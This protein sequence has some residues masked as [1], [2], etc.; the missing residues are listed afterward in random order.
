VPL[1][2]VVLLLVG[3]GVAQ[4]QIKTKRGKDAA[5]K[6][7]ISPTLAV[8]ADAATF[9]SS[10]SLAFDVSCEKTLSKGRL[11]L[12]VAVGAATN[13]VQTGADVGG[14]DAPVVI[15]RLH[16]TPELVSFEPTGHSTKA[17]WSAP[18]GDVQVK[19][20][21]GGED[22]KA[23][24][25]GIHVLI[26]FQPVREETGELAWHDGSGARVLEEKH[27]KETSSAFLQLFYS[28]LVNFPAALEQVADKRRETAELGF[29]DSSAATAARSNSPD[30]NAGGS[31]AGPN[32]DEVQSLLNR[33]PGTWSCPASKTEAPS[34][35]PIAPSSLPCI[36]DTY[37]WSAVL[38]AWAAECHARLSMES[39]AEQNAH[40]MM[41]S[42]NA[43]KSL[44]SSR[45]A[46]AGGNSCSTISIYSCSQ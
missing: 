13:D 25:R 18:R 28:S 14:W 21:T 26:H 40:Q 30:S 12:G 33:T 8:Y 27:P 45:P 39:E 34:V 42:L 38:Q 11:L 23:P 4:A 24:S 36:R 32:S 31:Y 37:V 19:H 7:D 44:C 35:R 2:G 41:Q 29:E 15:G 6:F 43:A 1:L 3:C 22:L 17:S 10:P 16:V 46:V 20:T 5:L 9:G